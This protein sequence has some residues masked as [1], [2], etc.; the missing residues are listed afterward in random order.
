MLAKKIDGLEIAAV[1]GKGSIPPNS[2]RPDHS[3]KG[4]TALL[5]SKA[6]HTKSSPGA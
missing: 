6:L 2:T 5:V 1:G 3:R 4:I